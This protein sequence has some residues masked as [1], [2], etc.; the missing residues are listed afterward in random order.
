MDNRNLNILKSLKPGDI[1]TAASGRK[2]VVLEANTNCIKKTMFLL[3]KEIMKFM[4]F[5]SVN[6]DFKYSN[7]YYYLNERDGYDILH[8]DFGDAMIERNIDLLSLDGLNTY[9][10]IE[11]KVGMLTL[12]QYR[13]YRRLIPMIDDTWWLAT[14]WS[15]E[16]SVGEELVLCIEDEDGNIVNRDYNDD[17]IGVRPAVKILL[18]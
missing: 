1:F 7:A 2:Y 16:E 6:N 5:D 13:K 18:E 9:E 17:S 12:D 4:E 11:A 10:C 14:P 3:S 8:E 15:T